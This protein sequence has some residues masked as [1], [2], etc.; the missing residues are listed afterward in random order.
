[1]RYLIGI[2][3]GVKT[4]FAIYD[5]TEKE[6]IYLDTLDFWNAI[7]MIENFK[8]QVGIS[9]FKVII[10]NPNLN[11]PTFNRNQ[12]AR[13]N[14][15]ISQN[16]G[17]NKRDASL[18]IQFCK[19]EG[20]EVQEIKPTATKKDA[21]FFSKITGYKGRCSQHGRDAALLVYGK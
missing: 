16:V 20:I 14:T 10:E 17:Q 18:L 7:T 2:D 9:Y 15:R 13:S 3:P 6:F 19:R 5:R 21:E 4:G 8:M 1:M 11:R 12:N